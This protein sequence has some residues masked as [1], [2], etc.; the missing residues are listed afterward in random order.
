MIKIELPEIEEIGNAE[1]L[2]RYGDCMIHFDKYGLPG[3]RDPVIVD[4]EDE[5]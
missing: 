4:I 5:E 1:T 2:I 3:Y